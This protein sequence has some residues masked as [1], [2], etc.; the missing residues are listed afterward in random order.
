MTKLT[1]RVLVKRIRTPEIT[2]GGIIIPE[3]IRKDEDRLAM[4]VEI[5]K[6]GESAFHGYYIKPVVGD[7]VN[8][9]KWAGAEQ[10]IYKEETEYR[11]VQDD[12]IICI[13]RDID[14]E[15]VIEKEREKEREKG[16]GYFLKKHLPFFHDFAVITLV[17]F[18]LRASA[19]R[20][21]MDNECPS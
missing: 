20:L 17:I 14:I 3:K 13:N 4:E 2:E 11:I 5:V 12:D 9:A 19:M 10:R 21:S 18:C 8:V 16:S 7:L 6:M 1:Y 15:K